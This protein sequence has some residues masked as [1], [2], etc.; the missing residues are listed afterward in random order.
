MTTADIA[1]A[2]RQ[3]ELGPPTPDDAETSPRQRVA[4]TMG[5]LHN[6]KER[7]RYA[8]YRTQGLPITSCHIESTIKKIN[9]RVKGSEKFWSEDGAEAILQLRADA[10]SETEPL[11][12]F[13]KRRQ[14]TASGQ[15]CY[16]N[17][18]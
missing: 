17:A 14:S 12:D 16:S 10:L 9:H 2:E 11:A 15:H 18:A 8:E 4:E 7:M 6:Q 3:A 5:Y 13:W 1:L